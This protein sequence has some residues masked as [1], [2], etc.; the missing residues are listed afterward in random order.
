[1]DRLRIRSASC[2]DDDRPRFTQIFSARSGRVRRLPPKR[3]RFHRSGLCFGPGVRHVALDQ[4]GCIAGHFRHT[5]CDLA[6]LVLRVLYD[7][8]S[9]LE[10]P[11]LRIG[12]I[13]ISC[14]VASDITSRFVFV[15]ATGLRDKDV[16]RD[17]L[18]VER[19]VDAGRHHLAAVVGGL[20]HH[21]GD[22]KKAHRADD[23][24]ES[25]Q[26]SSRQ[27][28]RRGLGVRRIE[29]RCSGF[30]LCNKLRNSVPV[31]CH[32]PHRGHSWRN[33]SHQHCGCGVTNDERK[34]GAEMNLTPVMNGAE[35]S[36]LPSAGTRRI[37]A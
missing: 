5:R 1:V 15:G 22:F 6:G 31:R 17:N 2:R 14:D 30:E 26:R 23:C 20:A 33:G 21:P 25:D 37:R 7:D 4:A 13:Q 9:H 8:V 35:S 32:G 3:D 24:A 12:T 28:Y 27:P 29:P 34:F 19:L 10:R 11:A 18:C 36:P 16:H